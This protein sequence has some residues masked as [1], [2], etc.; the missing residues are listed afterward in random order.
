MSD[1]LLQKSPDR[2]RL[3]HEPPGIRYSDE[4]RRWLVT[5][6]ALM[7]EV[8]YDDN[9]VVP[10]MDFT[11]L[12][13][14]LN[15]DLSA[16][17]GVVDWAPLVHEGEKHK[18]RREQLARLIARS[19]APALEAISAELGR[20]LQAASALPSRQPFCLYSTIVR[21]VMITGLLRLAELDLGLDLPYE[22]MPQML[23]QAL[24]VSKRKKINAL[25][26]KLLAMMPA[27]LSHDE[28]H[29]RAVIVAL[30]VNTLLGS[31]GLSL[32]HTMEQNLGK[33]LSE[34]TWPADLPRT[35]VPH[36]ERRAL[37]DR[38][39]GGITVKAGEIVRVYLEAAGL[40]AD[41]AC[42][43]S[44]VFFAL[45]SHK[46]VGLNFSRQTWTRF[47]AGFSSIHRSMKFIEVHEREQ[48]YLFNYPDRIMVEFN[49]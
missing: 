18:Y 41:G 33:L 28:I 4:L 47:V 10:G 19:T 12:T 6:P 29:V 13:Q 17:I 26:V 16:V 42:S 48:D 39:L 9:F 22:T 7:R 23:D 5:S 40:S 3:Y 32:V 27:E 30:G 49:D 38:E 14:H 8:L 35:A 11:Q 36:V 1:F 24:P 15:I 45:G 20:R 25:M 43:Y 21:P 2:A 31:L 44:D 46:C 34:M 37:E